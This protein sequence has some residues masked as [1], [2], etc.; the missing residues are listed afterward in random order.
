MS[1]TRQAYGYL[2]V[3]G[4]GQV[5]GSGLKRQ[6]ETIDAYALSAGL[7]IVGC[8]EDVHTGTEADRPGFMAMI[9]AM[10]SNSVR[11][12]IVE[13]LDRFARELAVQMTLLAKLQELGISL[14]SASTGQDVTADVRDDPMREA[15]VQVQGVFFQLDKRLLVRKLAKARRAKREASGRCEGRHFYGQHPAESTAVVERQVIDRMLALRRKRHDG[16]AWSYV[17][18]AKALNTEGH[19]TRY[20]KSWGASSVY[21]VIQR[22]RANRRSAAKG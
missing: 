18:I 4:Q 21:N 3:S 19:R 13:S 16:K 17:R 5:E 7:E 15:M 2:R 11:T 9:E 10:L 20:G 6:K 8:Y 14:I 12:I 1:T 22:Q